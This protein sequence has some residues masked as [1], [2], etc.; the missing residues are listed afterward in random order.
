MGAL[1]RASPS[2]ERDIPLA[3]AAG[4]P[5]AAVH[6]SARLHERTKNTCFPDP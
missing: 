6:F 1:D 5:L 2:M 3:R 4:I